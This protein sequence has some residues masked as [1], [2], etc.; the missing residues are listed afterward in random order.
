MISHSP[1]LS[2]H[3]AIFVR[4]DSKIKSINDLKDKEI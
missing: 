4:E 3:G 2:L 1:L